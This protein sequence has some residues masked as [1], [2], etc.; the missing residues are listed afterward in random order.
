MFVVSRAILVSSLIASMF[1]LFVCEEARLAKWSLISEC[2]VSW[3]VSGGLGWMSGVSGGGEGVTRSEWS[4]DGDAG[5]LVGPERFGA[6][7]VSL[8][9]MALILGLVAFLVVGFGLRW[10]SCD[11][12]WFAASRAALCLVILVEVDGVGSLLLFSETLA[13]RLV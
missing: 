2:R 7:P 4:V 6:A 13:F 9:I 3:R 12:T 11:T 1:M 5:C 10:C 8:L